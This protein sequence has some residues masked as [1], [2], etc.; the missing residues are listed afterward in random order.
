MQRGV[1]KIQIIEHPTVVQGGLDAN[2]INDP[3]DIQLQL[4]EPSGAHLIVQEGDETVQLS[5]TELGDTPLQLETVDPFI[6]T[7][8]A[9]REEHPIPIDSRGTILEP[10]AQFSEVQDQLPLESTSQLEADGGP[11]NTI[12]SE[13]PAVPEPSTAMY[14]MGAATDGITQAFAIEAQVM[15]QGHQFLRGATRRIDEGASSAIPIIIEGSTHD[16]DSI[17]VPQ[18]PDDASFDLAP[19]PA[20]LKV[21][22]TVKIM[23]LGII[24]AVTNDVRNWIF[25]SMLRGSIDRTHSMLAD[26]ER[27]NEF[28]QQKFKEQSSRMQPCRYRLSITKNELRDFAAM[29]DECLGADWQQRE[30]AL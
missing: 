27:Q 20:L 16:V 2:T 23:L 14:G 9:S 28:Q 4:E 12:A 25:L 15:Y 26:L 5:F 18:T 17:A 11:S 21:Q 10:P 29:L 30:E 7:E 3:A 8:A 13:L 24:Q 19:F 1:Q 6:N 22:D